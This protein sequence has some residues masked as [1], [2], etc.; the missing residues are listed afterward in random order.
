MIAAH[1]FGLFLVAALALLASPGPN[2]A[3]VLAHGA[4]HGP[5]GGIAAA[6]GIAA[7]DLV[8]TLLAVTGVSALL[9]AWAP[10][11]D[12]LR[13]AGA[14]YLLWLGW[15][16]WRSGVASATETAEAAPAVS[17]AAAT[18]AA[19]TRG[20]HHANARRIARRAALNGLFNPKALLFYML[21]LPQFVD[22][23]RGSVTLQLLVLGATLLAVALLV[24]GALG[25]A[26][27]RVARWLRARGGPHA[28][29]G[30]RLL[31]GTMLALAVRLLLLERPALR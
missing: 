21:F 15:R 16:A 25:L 30:H 28:R 2:M 8:H 29:W 20:I 31:A 26:A 27:G 10:A 11:F 19:T 1:T 14:L 24:H 4:A 13:S 7:A 3:F 22:A 5:R 18:K 6:L 23:R 9:A 12:L 17:G